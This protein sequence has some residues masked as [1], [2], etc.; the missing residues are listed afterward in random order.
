RSPTQRHGAHHDQ[1]SRYRR[2]DV[3]ITPGPPSRKSTA[4]G[5]SSHILRDG[6]DVASSLLQRGW[7]SADRT[8]TDDA[9][10][11]YGAH[12]RFWVEPERREEFGKVT[13]A[14]RCAWA[15]RRYVTAARVLPERTV[16]IRYE[17]LVFAPLVEAERVAAALDIAAD[18]LRAALG[19]AHA[20]S[21]GRWR[22]DLSSDQLADVEQEAGDLLAELGYR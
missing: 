10:Q 3:T 12:A 8:D 19:N 14:R 17:T 2:S 20:T 18:P 15:W 4:T 21:V 11:P 6:R 13:E 5:T 22:H 1:G 9:R 16:E 7:L